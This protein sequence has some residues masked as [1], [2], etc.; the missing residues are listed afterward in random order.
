MDKL[1]RCLALGNDKGAFPNEAAVAL[2]I[3]DT[4]MREYSLSQADVEMEAGHVKEASYMEACG[5]GARDLWPWEK[6]LGYVMEYL[7]PVK[8]FVK[9]GQ[10]MFVGAESDANLAAAF[11][12]ILRKELL[13]LSRTEPTPA[14]RRSF[15]T[16]CVRVLVER[17]K[18][19]KAARE[20]VPVVQGAE[21]AGFAV[22]VVKE[23]DLVAHISKVYHFHTTRMRGSS[24]YADSYGRGQSAGHAV[25]LSFQNQLA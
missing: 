25:N 3:A 8:Y 9:G 19:M 21:G 22:V 14:F 15:L 2:K 12:G 7:L 4:I 20:T 17:S 23:R 10:I 13:E 11:Y 16:G 6:T 5:H 18:D 24:L 1:K